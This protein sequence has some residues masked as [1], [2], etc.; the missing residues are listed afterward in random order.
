MSAPRVVV[1]G[2]GVMGCALAGELARGGAEVVV[3]ERGAVCSGSSGRN[4]GGVRQQF[5]SAA[6]VGLA[7]RTLERVRGFA[8]EFGVDVGFREVGYLFLAASEEGEARLRRTVGAQN[9]LG[10][11]SRFIGVDEIAELVPGVN[12]A[13]LRGGSFCPTDGHLDPHALVSGFAADARRH[14]AVIR[15]ET[16][17][18]GATRA[19]DRLA[20][21]RT[22]SGEVLTG[23]V[24]VNCA[25]A[26]AGAVAAL[27]GGELPIQPWRSQV[28][29]VT[30]TPPLGD[31]LPMTIDFENGKSYFHREGDGLL[32]GMDNETATAPTVDVA[33]DYGKV[34]QLVEHLAHRLPALADARVSTGWAGLLELTPDENPVV[35][36]T[37]LEN[38]YTA[39]GF[40]GHGLSIAPALAQDVARELLGEPPT[41]ALGAFRPE[42][43]AAAT[44][45]LE[46]EAL[47]MR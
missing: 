13:D 31:R 32:A 34:D 6:N 28:F 40:S 23:D 22:A 30:D 9:A 21:L 37:H 14:G 4:A 45:T 42:R 12:V 43:F 47:S 38:V 27:Y 11:P 1:V 20:G 39:A 17:V 35:G 5:S 19:G 18:V 46:V 8:D 33:F 41:G 3:V 44:A 7:R 25:G 26:W 16:A 10:V 15:Q 2:A 36:W 29:L 24:V